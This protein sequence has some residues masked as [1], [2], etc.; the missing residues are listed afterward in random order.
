MNFIILSKS[1]YSS[2]V[3]QTS[4]SLSDQKLRGSNCQILQALHTFSIWAPS[5]SAVKLKSNFINFLE[6]AH[7]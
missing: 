2:L 1:K 3:K 4:G 5:M 6:K 7:V